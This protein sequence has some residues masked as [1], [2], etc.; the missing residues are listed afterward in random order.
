MM[1]KFLL[2]LIILCMC[3]ETIAAADEPPLLD[4]P[5]IKT[6]FNNGFF[7]KG[8]YG[9]IQCLQ[10]LV[11]LRDTFKQKVELWE[12]INHRPMSKMDLLRPY[13]LKDTDGRFIKYAELPEYAALPDFTE[14]S[15]F[16]KI[17]YLKDN[18]LVLK[19][20]SAFR[21]CFTRAKRDPKAFR[22][23]S[24]GQELMLII[25]AWYRVN[26]IFSRALSLTEPPTQKS[27]RYDQ[28]FAYEILLE[29]VRIAPDHTLGICCD[30][31]DE[32]FRFVPQGK[33]GDE[34]EIRNLEKAYQYAYD[35]RRFKDFVPYGL[36]REVVSEEGLGHKIGRWI[37]GGAPP[38]PTTT[39]SMDYPESRYIHNVSGIGFSVFAHVFPELRGDIADYGAYGMEAG[40][41]LF[42][43]SIAPPYPLESLSLSGI[44]LTAAGGVAG[45]GSAA[46]AA[47]ESTTT[48]GL[49]A[50]GDSSAA[51]GAGGGADHHTEAEPLTEA[52]SLLLDSSGLRRR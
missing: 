13:L 46:A 10:G 8:G 28:L 1:I 11:T 29:V 7:L 26:R 39:F 35:T 18:Y 21:D 17:V 22:S 47:V 14:F 34:T 43:Y 52:A 44:S 51:G 3:K 20:T 23:D 36:L 12:S 38:V 6:M 24:L 16:A 32:A 27:N 4:S 30:R 25:I 42:S 50:A 45:A 49:G 9:E 31:T 41:R 33:T 19:T 37:R 48:L 5:T 2:Y 40:P 15:E